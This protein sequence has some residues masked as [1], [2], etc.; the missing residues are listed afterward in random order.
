LNQIKDLLVPTG[1]FF[2]SEWQFLNSQ[3]L[4]SKIIPWSTVGIDESELDQ[5]DYL[6]DWKSGG[7]GLRYVHH[8]GLGELESLA[9]KSGFQITDTFLSDG[10][11]GNLGL[12]QRWQK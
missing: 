3:R 10:A 6:L 1:V 12:Y 8:F 9:S 2:H 7:Y 4:R 11:S 5:H